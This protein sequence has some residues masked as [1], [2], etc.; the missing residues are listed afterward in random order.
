MYCFYT[1]MFRNVGMLKKPPTC[2]HLNVASYSRTHSPA[3]EEDLKLILS[4]NY[5]HFASEVRKS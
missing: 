3:S 1:E 4:G 5:L 2:K